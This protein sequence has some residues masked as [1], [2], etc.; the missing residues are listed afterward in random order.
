[1]PPVANVGH[2][3]AATGNTT[4]VR[5]QFYLK[6]F[7]DRVTA[8]ER[9]KIRNLMTKCFVANNIAFSIAVNP[10]FLAFVKALRPAFGSSGG[11]PTRRQLSGNLVNELY[12]DVKGKVDLFVKEYL[13]RGGK[14]TPLLDGWETTS[15][16]H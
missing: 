14:M 4:S 16:E 10:Y 13:D 15:K 5:G 6:K 7:A 12:D 8:G 11:L 2:F 3:R 9:E 1:M